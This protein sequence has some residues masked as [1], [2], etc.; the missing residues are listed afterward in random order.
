M[1]EVHMPLSL[2]HTHS[3]FD[4][5]NLVWQWKCIHNWRIYETEW[6]WP[7][8]ISTM[9]MHHQLWMDWLNM[10][11][12]PSWNRLL[13]LIWRICWATSIL[14]TRP[15]LPIGWSLLVLCWWGDIDNSMNPWSM[16]IPWLDMQRRGHTLWVVLPGLGCS[17]CTHL[18]TVK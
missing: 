16:V 12:K 15:Q 9:H 5:S 8:A 6:N 4:N 7:F 17:S 1:D 18:C 13:Q 10:L 14:H 11:C 3:K 2:D